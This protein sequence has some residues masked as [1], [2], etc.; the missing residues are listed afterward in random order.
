MK[1]YFLDK[2]HGMIHP[3]S[4]SSRSCIEANYI[5]L[6]GPLNFSLH[7]KIAFII[8]YPSQVSNLMAHNKQVCFR[9][10]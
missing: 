7:Y 5:K 9:A 4:C 1:L 3:F 8:Y 2:V 10:L 6:Y